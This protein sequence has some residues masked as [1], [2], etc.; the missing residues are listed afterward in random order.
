MFC[1]CQFTLC[2]AYA[3][4]AH[5]LII[6]LSAGQATVPSE[7]FSYGRHQIPPNRQI[8]EQF[9]VCTASPTEVDNYTMTFT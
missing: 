9:E 5:L 6:V 1:S 7:L 2:Q 3:Y 4:N 8:V